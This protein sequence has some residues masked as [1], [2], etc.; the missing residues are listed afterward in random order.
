MLMII[1]IIMV[2]IR[3]R[4]SKPKGRH[5]TWIHEELTN[6]DL[7]SKDAGTP[8]LGYVYIYIYIYTHI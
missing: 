1:I 7:I 8:F 3:R 6:H 4:G 5:Q 2:M